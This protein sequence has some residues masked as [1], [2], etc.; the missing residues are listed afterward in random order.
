MVSKLP[1]NIGI[2]CV[3]VNFITTMGTYLLKYDLHL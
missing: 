1:S 3:L 2:L